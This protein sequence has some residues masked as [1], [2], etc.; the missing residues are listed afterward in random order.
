MS[1]LDF[2]VLSVA[3]ALNEGM[4][5]RCVGIPKPFGMTGVIPKY[6]GFLGMTGVIPKYK[7]LLSFDFMSFG[8][9]DFFAE[10][11]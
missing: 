6:R 9:F 1:F 7:S 10:F 4:F 8:L 11:Y 5:N 2:D 3:C